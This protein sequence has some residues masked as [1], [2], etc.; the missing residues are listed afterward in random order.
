[1]PP[2][3]TILLGPVNDVLRFLKGVCDLE[4]FLRKHHIKG[5]GKGGDYN[6]P[7]IKDLI[8][9]EDKLSELREI[10]GEVYKDFVEHLTN[11]S[12]VHKVANAKELNLEEARK[13]INQFER[14]WCLMQAKHDLS[15]SLK[16]HII[17][18]HI[19][20]YMEKT[21]ETLLCV[22]DEIV[23]ATHSKLRK[24]DEKHQYKVKSKG[25]STHFQKQHKSTV[26]FN[27][28]NLGDI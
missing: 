25:S 14:H 4:P 15:E 21:G 24:Y 19:L 9:N 18:H 12:V 11:I 28:L 1:M 5:S 17:R 2:L 13:A 22:T 20:E 6:G 7:T 10:V 26:S 8:T 27:S 16:I 23:E 3:H